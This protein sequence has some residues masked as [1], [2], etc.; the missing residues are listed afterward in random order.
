[1]SNNAVYKLKRGVY[2]A[3]KAVFAELGGGLDKAA[4]VEALHAEFLSD[5]YSFAERAPKLPVI[6]KGSALEHTVTP[7][8]R[9]RGKCLV[10]VFANPYI[11]ESHRNNIHNLVTATGSAAG[12]ILNFDREKLVYCGVSREESSSITRVYPFGSQSF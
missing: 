10:Y 11:G 4:Y 12:V 3:A 5:P 7:D 2:T 1:M 6:Y 8:F 9:V